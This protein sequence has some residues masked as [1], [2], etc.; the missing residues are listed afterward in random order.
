VSVASGETL[1]I[2]SPPQPVDAPVVNYDG[3]YLTI[4]GSDVLISDILAALRAQSGAKI[5]GAAVK[6]RRTSQNFDHVPID[7]ALPRVL[8][9]NSY[10]ATFSPTPRANGVVERRLTSLTVLAAADP[11]VDAAA[12]GGAALA[13]EASLRRAAAEKYHGFLEKQANVERGTALAGA[14]GAKP[15]TMETLLE[16]AFSSRNSEARAGAVR[17]LARQLD[18]DPGALGTGHEADFAPMV[19]LLQATAG[20]SSKEFLTSLAA[21]LQDPSLRGGVMEMIRRMG[22]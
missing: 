2:A 22:H 8:G 4:H 16:V 17:A 10:M 12:Q 20:A 7:E 1:R 19:S 13:T 14:V 15:A 3:D 11:S 6:D 5:D 9:P 18:A 21:N